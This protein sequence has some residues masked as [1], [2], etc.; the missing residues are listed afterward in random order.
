MAVILLLVRLAVAQDCGPAV[1]VDHNC[2][3]IAESDETPVDLTDPECAANIDTYG[4]PLPSTDWYFDYATYGC[5]YS[6]WNVNPIATASAA[7][8]SRLASRTPI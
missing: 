2:N 1:P 7:A 5:E 3:G 8:T 4:D 6:L